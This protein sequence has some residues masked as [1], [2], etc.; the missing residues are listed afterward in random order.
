MNTVIMN[1]ILG[2]NKLMSTLFMNT[3]NMNTI[4]NILVYEYSDGEH[5]TKYE[6]TNEYTTEYEYSESEHTTDHTTV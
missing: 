4:L 1:I 6:Q 2:M 5:T 3:V